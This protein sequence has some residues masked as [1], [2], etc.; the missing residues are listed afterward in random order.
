MKVQLTVTMAGAGFVWTDGTVLDLS[1]GEARS[2]IA[3]GYAVEVKE[4]K[5]NPAPT[6]KEVKHA[7]TPKRKI[8]KR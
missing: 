2:L 8:E 1:D 3:A 5:E 4:E 7:V 6:V